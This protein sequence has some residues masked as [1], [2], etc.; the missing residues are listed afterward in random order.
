M[1]TPQELAVRDKKELV[2]KEEKTVPGRYYVPYGDIY[3]TDEA[4]T[5]VLEMPGVEKKDLEVALENDVGT[6]ASTF[7]ST[8]G[9]SR[10][11]PSITSAIIRDPSPYPTRSTGSTSAPS[12]RMAC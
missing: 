10:S 12:S 4:P 5:V 8:K 7:P 6:V 2:S 9:W 3:E 11:T 1:A